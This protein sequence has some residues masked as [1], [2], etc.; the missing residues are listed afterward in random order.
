MSD[1]TKQEVEKTPE[2]KKT[3]E[4]SDQDLKQVSGGITMVEL[5]AKDKDHKT[6]NLIR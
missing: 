5:S 4:L 2:E 1:E 6:S 3:V